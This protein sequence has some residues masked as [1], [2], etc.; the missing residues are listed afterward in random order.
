MA[1]RDHLRDLRTLS[2]VILVQA[3]W[4]LSKARFFAS[5]LLIQAW[6]FQPKKISGDQFM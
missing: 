5:D 6:D 4:S 2:L 3:T 1:N